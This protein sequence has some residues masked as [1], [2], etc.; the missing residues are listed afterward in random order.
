MIHLT[1]PDEDC[2]PTKTEI[3]VIVAVLITVMYFLWQITGV[4]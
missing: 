1:D 2:G 4:N 3:I